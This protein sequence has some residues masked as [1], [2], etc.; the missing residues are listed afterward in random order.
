MPFTR[1]I[2]EPPREIKHPRLTKFERNLGLHI[3]FGGLRGEERGSVEVGIGGGGVFGFEVETDDT[4]VDAE[5]VGD[6]AAAK[7][8]AT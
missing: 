8:S 6:G 7:R 5:F 3:T 4:D 1:R 2:R